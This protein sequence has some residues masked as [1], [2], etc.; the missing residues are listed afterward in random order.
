MG[1]VSIDIYTCHISKLRPIIGREY[2]A[3]KA[4]YNICK[5]IFASER[6]K[7]CSNSLPSDIQK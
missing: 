3:A 7:F 2:E 6:K 5:N 1:E 4:C